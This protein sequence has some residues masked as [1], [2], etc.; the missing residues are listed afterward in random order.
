MAIARVGAAS[1]ASASITSAAGAG[2]NIVLALAFRSTAATIPTLP[3]GWTSLGSSSGSTCAY[4]AAYIFCPSSSAISATFTGATQIVTMRYSGVLGIGGE[5]LAA[6]ASSA[7]MNYGALTMV[8]TGGKSWAVAFGAHR[9]ASNVN[10]APTGMATISGGSIGT[11]PE[12][13][14]FDTNGAVSSWS[15]QTVTVNATSG[16]ASVVFELLGANSTINPY[17]I[18]TGVALSNTNLTYTLTQNSVD[19]LG[20]RATWPREG[21]KWKFC[22]TPSATPGDATTVGIGIAVLSHSTVSNGDSSPGLAQ[23]ANNI[24][25]AYYTDGGGTGPDTSFT[26]LWN[27]GI[28]GTVAV[29]LDNLLIWFYPGTTGLWNGSM[30]A[31]PD[32]GIGGLALNAAITGLIFPFVLGGASGNSASYD[33]TAAG[34]PSSAST[35]T[36]WDGASGVTISLGSASSSGAV[37]AFGRQ[38]QLT[39]SGGAAVGAAAALKSSLLEPTAAATGTATAAPLT[40]EGGADVSLMAVSANA[41]ALGLGIQDAASLAGAT[42][43]GQVAGTSVTSDPVFSPA[44]TTAAAPGLVPS[45]ASSFEGVTSIG[46]AGSFMLTGNLNLNLPAVIANGAVGIFNS[47]LAKDLVSVAVFGDV[48]NISVQENLGLIGA[49]SLGHAAA[50]IPSQGETLHAIATLGEIATFA[51]VLGLD[52]VPAATMAAAGIFVPGQ[53]V[54]V[55]LPAVMGFA[56]VG[57]FVPAPG[58]PSITADAI[59]GG[60]VGALSFTFVPAEATAWAAMFSVFVPASLACA[61]ARTTILSMATPATALPVTATAADAALFNAAPLTARCP[62]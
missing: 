22:F 52:L 6:I 35:F 50:P 3:S 12:A 55:D 13:A 56:Q 46:H 45:I 40:I 18:A 61:Q 47:S 39:M 16:R 44:S 29:D 2:G 26:E 27:L 41:A 34:A 32:T 9:T 43:L 58:L 42:V 21:G 49:A 20:A 30:T 48:G 33:G 7:T 10:T 36:P 53:G 62:C 51:P 28:A 31:N 59:A 38:S 23:Y 17:D 5:S 25:S 57:D 8:Q 24:T 11:G 14:V 1:A 15:A 54:D 60:M 4:I 19:I 37:A